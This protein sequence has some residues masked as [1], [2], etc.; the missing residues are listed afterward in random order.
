[1]LSTATLAEVC[2]PEV[3]LPAQFQHGTRRDALVCGERALM[4][5]VLED[6]IRCLQA[7]GPRARRAAVEAAE[8]IRSVDLEWPF[9]FENLCAALE[10]DA[11]RLRTALLGTFPHPRPTAAAAAVYELKLRMKPAGRALELPK[12]LRTVP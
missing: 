8:W 7:P 5:A 1:M 4:L 9:S 2:H 10:L 12:R 6:A 3:V 11:G